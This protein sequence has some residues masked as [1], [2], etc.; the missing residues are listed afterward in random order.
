[1]QRRDAVRLGVAVCL[2]L[3]TVLLC[4]QRMAL[5]TRYSNS[6][7]SFS[8]PAS[9]ILPPSLMPPLPQPHPPPSQLDRRNASASVQPRRHSLDG[10]FVRKMTDNVRR[11][12][13]LSKLLFIGDVF[14]YEFP[15]ASTRW[16]TLEA[17]YAAVNLGAPGER[18]EHVLHRF[19]R[20][21]LLLNI[22]S[23]HPMVLVMLGASNIH[24]GDSAAA[25]L[26]GVAAVLALLAAHL[27][28]PT[29]VVLSVLP[30]PTAPASVRQAIA[31]VNRGLASAYGGSSGSG[32][33][34][35]DYMDITRFF[36]H[37]SNGTAKPGMYLPDLTN[38]SAEG[39]HT[40]VHELQGHFDRLPT[41]QDVPMHAPLLFARTD[42]GH[43]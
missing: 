2:V 1:M 26:R 8:A 11:L 31:D 30:R 16:G 38:P 41:L 39:R 28:S 36:V 27:R 14:F 4:Y 20:G 21:R 6:I 7:T 19:H 33:K 40:V 12:G 10:F 13:R 15:K 22:T 24:V 3:A 29:L 42:G 25:V 37:S 5:T 9:P 34:V 23:A 35:T 18:T 43:G 32:G 17:K